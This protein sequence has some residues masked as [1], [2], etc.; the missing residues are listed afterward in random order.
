ML[1]GRELDL[2]ELAVRL[3]AG[4]DDLTPVIIRQA[5]RDA[6]QIAAEH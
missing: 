6:T 5:E 2:T 4:Q 1:L 3:L